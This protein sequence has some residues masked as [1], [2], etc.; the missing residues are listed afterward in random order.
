LEKTT[1]DRLQPFFIIPEKTKAGYSFA[2]TPIKISFNESN[3]VFYGVPLEFSTSFGKG[4]SRGPEAIRLTSAL[5]VETF[6]L[7]ENIDIYDRVKIYDLGDIILPSVLSEKNENDMNS[8]LLAFLD[9]TLPKITSSICRSNKVPVMMGGEHTL[10]YYTIKAVAKEQPLL[11]HFD[12]HRDMKPEYFGMKLCHTT[13]F[14]HLMN[15]GHIPGGDIIQIGIRQ[16]DEAE[17]K[18]AKDNEVI[19]FDAWLVHNKIERL[20]KFL[21]E[22]T[23]GRKIYMS[24][25]I[26][27]YDLPFVSCTG[28]PEPFGLNPFEVV[29][30]LKSISPSA[31][32]VGLDITEV[33]VKNDDY[34]EG[35]LATQTLLRILSRDYAMPNF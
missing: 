32:L 30:I 10:S 18:I 2:D 8:K 26:D 11:I 7:D 16:T 15:E 21:K 24:F 20:L 27:V 35:T 31:R 6:L 14:Y 29:Q 13:P 33:A 3:V 1:F 4:A 17:N 22:V 9:K 34:R 28:T 19:T 5:Q 23:R 12:A 25:D